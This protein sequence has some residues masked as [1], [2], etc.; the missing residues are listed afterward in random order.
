MTFDESDLHKTEY[1]LKQKY[2]HIRNCSNPR[3]SK[4]WKC[5]KLCHY[6]KSTFKDTNI[7]QLIEY[8]D[9]QTCQKDNFMTMCE[10]VK[11][12]TQLYGIDSVVDKYT[13]PGY[14][15]GHYQAPGSTE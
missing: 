15:V 10:Q 11:H 3:L 7:D 5:T 8:R 13:R 4:S 12:D 14:N 2:D 6:G 1:L 9:G